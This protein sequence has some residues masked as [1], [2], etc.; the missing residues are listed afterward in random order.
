MTLSERI[1]RAIS[2][3]GMSKAAVGRAVGLSAGRFYDRERGGTWR[4]HEVRRIARV[5]GTTVEE[6]TEGAPPEPEPDTV[7]AR[8]RATAATRGMFQTVVA[9]LAGID[10]S[11]WQRR[12]KSDSWRTGELAAIARVLRVRLETLAGT[13]DESG[14]E[15]EAA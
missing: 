2:D 12:A 3:A 5:L 15:D 8:I 7:A 10:Q 1:T 6:L 9:E 4:P 14:S 11:T 13:W